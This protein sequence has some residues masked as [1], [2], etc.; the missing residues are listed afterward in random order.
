[1]EAVVFII[2]QEAVFTDSFP[3]GDLYEYEWITTDYEEDAYH[4]I[5]FKARDINENE[6][7]SFESSLELLNK[8]ENMNN[9]KHYTNIDLQW[10]DIIN[11]YKR[12]K[13]IEYV[14]TK[15][16]LNIGDFIKVAKEISELSKKLYTL[17]DDEEFYKIYKMFDNKLIQ[18]TMS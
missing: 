13:N 12:S 14:V 11:E 1:M 6:Y 4:Q 18:K 16:N 7:S 8:L 9:L 5:S 15:F 17:Y 10:F 3:D 2:N